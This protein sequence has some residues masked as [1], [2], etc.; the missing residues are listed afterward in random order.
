VTIYLIKTREV[1]KL[2]RGIQIEKVN[3]IPTKKYQTAIKQTLTECKTHDLETVNGNLQDPKS[4][5]KQI[6]PISPISN[7]KYGLLRKKPNTYRH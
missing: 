6:T 5:H 3:I 4:S 1:K 7:W 2:D